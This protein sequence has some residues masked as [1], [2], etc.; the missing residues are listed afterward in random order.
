M[1]EINYSKK[2][3]KLESVLREL[4]KIEVVDKILHEIQNEIMRDYE[5]DFE[6][7]GDLKIGDQIRKTHIRFRKIDDYEPYM[8]AVHQDY[9]SQDDIFNGFIY[10]KYTPQFNKVN[11]SQ[12]ANG[13]NFKHEIT[14]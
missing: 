8:N 7:V 4:I 10:K 14:E 5:G 9:E 12:Y 3:D 6:M 1:V 2:P 11:K 13:C